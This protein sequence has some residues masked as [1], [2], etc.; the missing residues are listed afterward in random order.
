VNPI[1][2]RVSEKDRGGQKQ[3]QAAEKEAWEKEK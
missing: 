3:K 2:G 1:R